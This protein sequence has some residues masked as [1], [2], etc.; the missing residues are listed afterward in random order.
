MEEEQN[1]EQSKAIRPQQLT[2]LCIITF[3]SSGLYALFFLLISN[4]YQEMIDALRKEYVDSPE[5]SFFLNAP[6]EF[7]LLSFFLFAFSVMG[8]VL[9]WKLRK[10]GFHIYTSAQIGI[11]ILLII[12]FYNDYIPVFEILL[13]ILFVYLYARN[14]KFMR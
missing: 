7:F 5:F 9:M 3:I 4:D 11:L 13:T 1:V 14:L 8:A 10:V 6:K 2:I 12:F